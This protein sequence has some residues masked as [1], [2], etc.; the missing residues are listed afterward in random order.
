MK[1][2]FLTLV[3]LLIPLAIQPQ[4]KNPENEKKVSIH[5]LKELKIVDGEI[6]AGRILNKNLVK[7]K[8][9]HWLRVDD[10]SRILVSIRFKS[11][12]VLNHLKSIGC[13]IK[14][15][16]KREAYV[17]IPFAKIEAVTKLDDVIRLQDIGRGSVRSI[18]TEG[19]EI[20]RGDDAQNSFGAFGE[21]IT[22]GVI[23][24]GI[25]RWE[26]SRSNGDL[27]QSITIVDPGKGS[28]GTAMM[29]I[30][31]DFAPQANYY[32][33][34]LDFDTDG[35]LDMRDRITALM[36][37]GCKVIVDDIGWFYGYS[38]FQENELSWAI[39]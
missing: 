29:E 21:N 16:G 5:I 17:W 20:L 31:Y 8:N 36:Y 22:V 3:I 25:E 34:G 19:L 7:E 24:D 26:E 1:R 30:I 15:V 6:K 23:S 39:D 14:T 18:T 2:F 10:K 27:P 37:Q 35:P 38:Y 28:E 9:L 32:F 4:F 13:E 11:S 12:N 33:G